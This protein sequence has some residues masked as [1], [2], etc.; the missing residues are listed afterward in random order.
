MGSPVSCA[1]RT[2]RLR[3]P[4]METVIAPS[5][6]SLPP[7]LPSQIDLDFVEFITHL[8]DEF[9][10]KRSEHHRF[11]RRERAILVGVTMKSVEE[12]RERL[13]ELARFSEVVVLDTVVQ[14]RTKLDPRYL[15]GKARSKSSSS[16]PYKKA[17]I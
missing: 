2:S 11:D 17:P 14:K 10:E 4:T 13:A 7:V 1:P 6:G 9:A 16:T 8:E 12:A 5:R 3:P 15:I